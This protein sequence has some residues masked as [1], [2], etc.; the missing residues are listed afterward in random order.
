M[1]IYTLFAA[2]R[3][4]T[5]PTR[6][7]HAVVIGGSIA[8]LLAA[9]V[10][11]EH[12]ERVTIIERDQLPTEPAFRPGVPQMRHVHFLLVRGRQILETLFPGL[13]AELIASGAQVID[14]CTDLESYGPN[15]RALR[16]ESDLHTLAMSRQLLEWT[17]RRRV[18]QHARIQVQEA[19][20]VRDLVFNLQATHIT[21]VQVAP[22]LPTKA[23]TATP[24]TL[25]ADLVVDASGRQSRAPEWLAAH[26]YDK[27]VE[28]VIDSGMGYATRYYQFDPSFQ[29]PWKGL[30]IYTRTQGAG[31]LLLEQGQWVCMLTGEGSEAPPTNEAEFLSIIRNL[32]E[33]HI[34]EALKHAQ[35]ISPIYGYRRT[36]N[37]WRH[38]E[39]L[40]RQ[41]DNFV[42]LGDAVCAFNPTYG[43]GMT[44]AALGA[45]TL[46]RCLRQRRGQRAGL[47]ARFQRQLARMLKAPWLMA[48]SADTAAARSEADRALMSR[49]AH[50]Y[51]DQLYLMTRKNS[52]IAMARYRVMHLVAPPSSLLLPNV[53]LPIIGNWL[54]GA[55]TSLGSTGK[56]RKGTAHPV[57]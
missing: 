19:C 46:A 33:L 52:R 5:L 31:L 54:H 11:T 51:I 23:G 32:S 10:L 43:Q 1:D 9:W 50:A 30:S 25:T 2:P 22:R 47:A 39:R 27:P 57:A 8:G 45:M 29:P 53:A 15:G 12:A 4:N 44:C 35:P 3:A 24:T 6:Y 36:E 13:G 18:L 28:T 40:R 16:F 48:T 21:G 41:P 42:V 49:L 38:Y 56:R 55:I 26:G 17:I 37:C 14:W 20:Q 7:E 34:S